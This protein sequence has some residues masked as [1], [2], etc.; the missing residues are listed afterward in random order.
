MKICY[1]YELSFGGGGDECI[2][3]IFRLLVNF[4]SPGPASLMSCPCASPFLFDRCTDWGESWHFVG[5]KVAI[6]SI[7]TLHRRLF[8]KTLPESYGANESRAVDNEAVLCYLSHS[9]LKLINSSEDRR[10]CGKL[11]VSVVCS[12]CGS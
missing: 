12:G 2:F 7:T 1:F 9:D 4:F 3:R 5:K 11:M 8:Y 6:F 10:V